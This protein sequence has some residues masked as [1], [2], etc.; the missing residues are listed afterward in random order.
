MSFLKQNVQQT[1][2]IGGRGDELDL[3]LEPELEQALDAFRLSVH[4]L[5]EAAYSRPRTVTVLT[6]RRVWRQAAGWALGCVLTAG[7]VSTGFYEQHQR[8]VAAQR[9][10]QQAEQNRLAAQ[11][12]R[13]Q[14]MR[15]ED[16]LLAKVDSDVAREVPSAME[17]L[18]QLVAEDESE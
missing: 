7:I 11:Q 14:Q 15:E 8:Q 9:A 3:G 12:M 6:H 10:A 13:E 18:A 2:R 5:S 16:E 1:E 4:A 17:P